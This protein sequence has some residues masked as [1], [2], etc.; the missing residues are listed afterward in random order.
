MDDFL[1][2]C[3]IN[4][5]LI[6]NE[7]RSPMK[8]LGFTRK[9]I[10]AATLII[11]TTLIIA[12]AINYTLI[13]NQVEQELQDSLQVQAETATNIIT[14]WLES[15]LTI[16]T[17]LA[18]SGLEVADYL[19][20]SEIALIKTAGDFQYVYI[21]SESGQMLMADANEVL[22]DDYDP[23]VRPWYIETKSARKALFTHPYL[24]AT[25]GDILFSVTAPVIRNGSFKGVIAGDLT[26]D[27]ASQELS[28]INFSG[29]GKVYLIDGKGEIIMHPDSAMN[30]KHINALYDHRVDLNNNLVHIEDQSLLVGLFALQGIPS[31]DWQL[32]VEIDSHQAFSFLDS[33]RNTAL[34][35]APFMLIAS[36]LLLLLFLLKLTKPLHIL[37]DAMA[38]ITDGNGDLTQR[39]AVTSQDELGKL[40]GHF[41]HFVG[42]IHDMMQIFQ[43]QS[44]EV[45]NIADDMRT[46][47]NQS[48][49]DMDNQRK[50]TEQVATAVAEMSAA[51]SEI[52]MNAQSASE[53]AQEADNEGHT[54]SNVVGE[55]IVSIEGLA[56]NLNDA[57]RVIEE[58]EVEVTAIGSVLDVIKGIADQTNLLALNA[59]IE[60]ARAGEHGKGFAVVA[61]EV[62]DL[63]GKTQDST[64]EI[65]IKI[66]SLQN[67]A[68]RAVESMKKSRDISEESV[69]KAGLAGES[70]ARISS[71]ISRISEMNLHIATASEQ[72]TCV[73]EEIAHN[74]TKI[75]DVT[76]STYVVA[77]EM[78]DTSDRLSNISHKISEDVGAFKL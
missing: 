1:V 57:E 30:G 58:L 75:S 45:N 29:M 52:A 77:N 49:H 17:A 67:G 40:A 73:T 46:I 44:K 39:L 59:A 31:I 15:K 70:L 19:D 41:N 68:K 61:S 12:S 8:N 33:M 13:K 4:L 2:N 72:Q 23:T 55:A 56:N 51:A 54:V 34:V 76:E 21:A 20:R 7:K 18:D 64:E 38:D 26:L 60:A 66:S 74:M 10:T 3:L 62:R 42:H 65:N 53:A 16:V 32:A 6:T 11:T 43:S 47:S 24:N 27:F 69:S 36:L 28:K 78:V 37:E 22:P 25:S 63:A 5:L 14:N 9:I 50:E 35:L 71:S 48:K